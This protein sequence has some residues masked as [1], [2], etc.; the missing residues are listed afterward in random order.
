ME[1][2]PCVLLTGG[3]GYIGSHICYELLERDEYQIVVLD[4]LCNSSWNGLGRIF[5]KLGRYCHLIKGDLCQLEEVE[6]VFNQKPTMH[7]VVG[8]LFSRKIK[9]FFC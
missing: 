1:K 7:A 5:E 3:A 4:N 9:Q 2:K 6:Q 8:N